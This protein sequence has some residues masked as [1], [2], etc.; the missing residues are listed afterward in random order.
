MPTNRKL[1]SHP[2]HPRISPEAIALF[3]AAEGQPRKRWAYTDE[4]RQ[5]ARML[6]PIDEWWTGNTPLDKS[7]GPC[8]PPWCVAYTDWHRCR[9]VRRRMIAA[10]AAA[11][12]PVAAAGSAVVSGSQTIGHDR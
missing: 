1:R 8:H 7:R 9:A 6:G 11:D 3:R 4:A 2:R 10:A 12:H 5:L